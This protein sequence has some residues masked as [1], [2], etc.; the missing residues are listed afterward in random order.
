[1]LVF[2][3]FSILIRSDDDIT[4]TYV[5]KTFAIYTHAHMQNRVHGFFSKTVSVA[6]FPKPCPW[7][8][9]QNRVRGFFSA[10]KRVMLL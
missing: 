8:L 5:Y 9:F 10:E 3:F 1:M 2:F 6:S 7:L 4:A